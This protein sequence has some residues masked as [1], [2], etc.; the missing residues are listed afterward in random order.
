LP[1]L[2]QCEGRNDQVSRLNKRVEFLISGFSENISGASVLCLGAH[3][4]RWAY[5]FAS[6]CAA[7][8]MANGARAD[9]AALFHDHPEAA[10]KVRVTMRSQGVFAGL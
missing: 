10:L 9:V 7:K 2:A 4:H 8:V 6:A 3:D 1:E 5:S